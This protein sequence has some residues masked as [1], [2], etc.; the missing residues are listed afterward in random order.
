M[1]TPTLVTATT[2]V[3]TPTLVTIPSLVTTPHLWLPHTCDYPHTQWGCMLTTS[4]KVDIS[5]SFLFVLFKIWDIYRAFCFLDE[6]SILFPS[7]VMVLQSSVF[8]VSVFLTVKI[9]RNWQWNSIIINHM[10]KRFVRYLTPKT[11]F[12]VSGYIFRHILTITYNEKPKFWF[13]PPH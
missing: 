3:T 9:Y 6:G 12:Y 5:E 7:Q 4:S 8:W 10:S 1:T 2:L 13:L 11:C